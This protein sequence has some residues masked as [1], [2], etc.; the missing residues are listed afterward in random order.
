MFFER[1]PAAKLADRAMAVLAT[2]PNPEI[3]AVSVVDLGIVR[4]V[5]D[6]AVV[7]TLT[8]S[9]CP[10]TMSSSCRSARRS[11]VRALILMCGPNSPPSGRPIGSPL[12]SRAKLRAFSIAPPPLGEGTATSKNAVAAECPR[13]G[14]MDT[15]EVSHFGPPHVRRFGSATPAA[16]HS[17][18]LNATSARRLPP[19]RHCRHPSRDQRLGIAQLRRAARIRV[20]LRFR[21]GQ[22]VTLRADIDG[23]DVRRTYSLYVPPHEGELHVAVKAVSGGRFSAFAHA[24]AVGHTIDVLPSNGSFT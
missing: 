16:S 18:D 15:H 6:G 4:G 22:H 10:A 1:S 5:W 20:A 14:S 11:H 13:C 2:I 21:A 7:I 8:Y 24:L 23:E 19:A 9:G 3:P 17:I 12:K